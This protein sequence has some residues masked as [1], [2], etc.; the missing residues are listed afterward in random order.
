MRFSTVDEIER[1]IGRDADTHEPPLD[2]LVEVAGERL[3]ERVTHR[4]RQRG[5]NL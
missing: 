2:H 5:F 1:S 3:L 4:W